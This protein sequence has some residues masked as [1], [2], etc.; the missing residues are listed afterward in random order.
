MR[1][2]GNLVLSLGAVLG[3]FPNFSVLLEILLELYSSSLWPLFVYLFSLR[4]CLQP[5]RTTDTNQVFTTWRETHVVSTMTNMLQN[6]VRLSIVSSASRT[7]ATSHTPVSTLR[8]HPQVSC[9]HQNKHTS[10]VSS[11][12]RKNG[13]TW[14][15]VRL[16][17][18][19][20]SK[21]A[22]RGRKRLISALM[23][24]STAQLLVSGR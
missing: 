20:A 18:T 21:V 19:I 24:G 23:E 22:L 11:N 17:S 2:S 15:R 8:A 16:R 7:R 12:T 1:F 14:V 5:C 9:G 13:Q 4:P 6:S 3:L 10:T